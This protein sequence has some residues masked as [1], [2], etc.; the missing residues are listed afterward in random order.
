MVSN[1]VPRGARPARRGRARAALAAI[2]RPVALAGVLSV[3]LAAA[4]WATS[5]P[6]RDISRP[7]HASRAPP[8]EA[9]GPGLAPTLPPQTVIDERV[10][11]QLHV[12]VLALTSDRHGRWLARLQAGDDAPRLAQPG[13]VLAHGLRV[14]GIEPGRVILRRGLQLEMLAAPAPALTRAKP[15]EPLPAPQPAV[16]VSTPGH[17]PPRTSTVDRAIQR[18][19]PGGVDRTYWESSHS[20]G[21]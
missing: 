10:A 12:R 4:L 8:R 14:E 19:V 16:I 5:T 11:P 15:V 3:A 18:A 13:D 9:G 17:E 21:H 6:P 7:Q 20:T 1:A 2:G